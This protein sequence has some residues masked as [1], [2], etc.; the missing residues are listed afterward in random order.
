MKRFLLLLLFVNLCITL[1]T[2]TMAT[3]LAGQKNSDDS[4]KYEVI[5]WESVKDSNN[6]KMFRSYLKKYPNG[7]FSELAKIQ[8][9]HLEEEAN[10]TASANSKNIITSK[11]KASPLLRNTPV[12]LDEPELKKMLKRYNFYDTER[13]NTGNFK[14]N[15]KDN[16]DGTITDQATGLI[17]QKS[18][19]WK[20][21]NRKKADAYIHELNGKRFAGRSNWRLPTVE[22]LASLIER[23]P[24]GHYWFYIDPMFDK[25][26]NKSS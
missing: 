15:F 10:N 9:E 8:I 2:G 22:E 6:V 7:M 21:I 20:R 19:S 1:V 17:W 4:A 14:N 11:Q 3:T 5:Y 23:S 26:K 24:S 18:G 13:N 12:R 16:N 25:A